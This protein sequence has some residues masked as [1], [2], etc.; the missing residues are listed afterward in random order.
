MADDDTTVRV[1]TDTWRRL[2]RRKDPG[3]SFDDVINELLDAVESSE[4]DEGN[5]KT[6]VA[7]IQLPA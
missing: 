3:Q 7:E 1:G 4:G 2:N 5:P 6:P